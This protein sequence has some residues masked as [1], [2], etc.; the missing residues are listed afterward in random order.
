M[1]PQTV[2]RASRSLVVGTILHVDL[3]H[4]AVPVARTADARGTLLGEQVLHVH[5]AFSLREGALTAASTAMIPVASV[6]QWSSASRI[7]VYC[8]GGG[9]IAAVRFQ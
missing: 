4:R 6:C 1:R 7:V 2:R 9:I 8:H 5:S 3:L